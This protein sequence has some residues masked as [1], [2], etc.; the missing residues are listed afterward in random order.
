MREKL[1]KA[2]S[3]VVMLSKYLVIAGAMY[4]GLSEMKSESTQVGCEIG[5]HMSLIAISPQLNGTV[6]L[7]EVARSSCERQI[8]SLQ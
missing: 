7:S 6:A 1:K 2:L 3:I 5:V 4:L 8:E